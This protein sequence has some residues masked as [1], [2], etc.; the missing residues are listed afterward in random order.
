MFFGHR[1]QSAIELFETSGLQELKLHTQRLRCNLQV[2]DRERV[3]WVGRVGKDR[4]IADLGH[5]FLKQFELL[6]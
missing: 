4:H 3:G 5:R 6:P 2:S 1:S